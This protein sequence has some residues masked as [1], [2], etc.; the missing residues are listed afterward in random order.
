MNREMSKKISLSYM[1][2]P[3]LKKDQSGKT[4]IWE[5]ILISP[6]PE[7][8]E[9]YTKS[10]FLDGKVRETKPKI[11]KSSAR[12]TARENA[13]T[14]MK[15]KW[16]AKKRDGYR[17]FNSKNIPR[18]N[19]SKKVQVRNFIHPMSAYPIENNEHKLR[20]PLYAQAKLDGFRGMVR[21]D[22]NNVEISSRK[23]LPFPHLKKIKEQLRT[24]PLLKKDIY[25]DGEIY[26]H[27]HSV[28]DLKRVLGRKTIESKEV[29]ELEEKIR[30][31]IFDWFDPNNLSKPFQARWDELKDA[32]KRWKI[33]RDRRRVCL[34]KMMIV[35][36][37][38]SLIEAR[39]RYISEGY[40][41][42]VARLPLGEYRPG[43]RSPAVF[44][45]KEFKRS[46]FK[47]INALEGSGDDRGTVIWVLQCLH[48]K[49]R[50]FQA[51]PMGTREERREWF[52]NKE[53][54]IGKYLE[55]KY[56]AIDS[57]GCV[58]RFPVGIRFITK[59]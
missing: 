30:F 8:A 56:M 26:L 41:G 23:G 17:P 53:R 15:S 33:P 29:A 25:L 12:Q 42:V 45:S 11:F 32:F 36:D 10:G 13:L 28:F 9:V 43:K 54:Y 3:P 38:P 57:S 6:S 1:D 21:L 34:D 14:Y 24:F 59:P 52:K 40:E 48:D 5:V 31:V 35:K 27:N 7:K 37:L 16:T 47:I 18:N 22:M 55:V 4:R 20:F 49:K 2:L 58:T 19:R 51:R 46:A 39:D 44:R 50:S